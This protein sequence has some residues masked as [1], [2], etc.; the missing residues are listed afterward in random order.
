MYIEANGNF[1]TLLRAEQHILK[2]STFLSLAN[3]DDGYT[4]KNC[5]NNEPKLLE[6]PTT[7]VKYHILLIKL[8]F[9]LEL[10]DIL[11]FWPHPHFKSF[12]LKYK[13]KIKKCCIYPNLTEV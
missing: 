7:V 8:D 13:E 4:Q 2:L 5:S 3:V 6:S 11:C 9:F 1:K 12:V 10:F